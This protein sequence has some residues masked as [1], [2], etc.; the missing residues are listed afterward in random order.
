MKKK[1]EAPLSLKD[2][3]LLIKTFKG[4]ADNYKIWK[5]NT[6][7]WTRDLAD[8]VRDAIIISKLEDEAEKYAQGCPADRSILEHLDLKYDNEIT[9]EKNFQNLLE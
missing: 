1:E 5:Q 7:K 6:V 8:D 4:S 3:I 2:K 9:K